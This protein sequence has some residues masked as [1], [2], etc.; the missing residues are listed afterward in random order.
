ML[1]TLG[2]LLWQALPAYGAATGSGGSGGSAEYR[3]GSDMAPVSASAAMTAVPAGDQG[4]RAER[5]PGIA[6][7]H[8]R[9]GDLAA[10]RW[11][12]P[13]TGDGLATAARTAPTAQEPAGDPRRIGNGSPLTDV[14]PAGPRSDREP[15]GGGGVRD[16][17]AP[18]D[19]P[20]RHSGPRTG[21][22][23]GAGEQGDEDGNRRS[24][25]QGHHPWKERHHDRNEDPDR[26]RD[27]SPGD[28]HQGATRDGAGRD[29]IGRDGVGRD[30]TGRD[31]AGRDGRDASDR[32]PAPPGSAAEHR[33]H[34][35]HRGHG[36]PETRQSP[37]RRAPA[38]PSAPGSGRD[39]EGGGP[40]KAEDSFP[41][42]DRTPA[43]RR[44]ATERNAERNAQRDGNRTASDHRTRRDVDAAGDSTD[45]VRVRA[46][47]SG[48]LSFGAG[49][50]LIGLGI[51]F[52][53]VRLRRE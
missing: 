25:A 16:D 17:A 43:D 4:L 10:L 15:L 42:Q 35:E 30:M 37:E 1:L 27:G 19:A 9:G 48:L 20:A 45:R 6:R 5:D 26:A 11:S 13:T 49:L 47:T 8:A 23:G 38:D 33:A 53:G 18:G 46:S 28:R 34:G 24:D 39:R 29:G 22:P 12:R 51:G 3:V 2:A 14:D 32:Q 52:L 41:K 21:G 31:G 7:A 50:L 44:G 40:G 36:N